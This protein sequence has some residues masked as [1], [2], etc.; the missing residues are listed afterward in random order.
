Q[1]STDQLGSILGAVQQLAGSQGTSPDNMQ[2]LMSIVGQYAR[3]S[4]KQT[5]QSAGRGEAESI[6][7]R[8]AGTGPS[9]DAMQA[10]FSPQQ[11]EK[12]ADT[13]SQR[14]GLNRDVIL[15]LLPIVVPLVLK[16]LQTGSSKSGVSRQSQPNSV[17]NIFLDSDNDGDVDM[18]D[19]ISVAS[20]F[21]KNR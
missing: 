8:F 21:L 4:L 11:R 5:S 9:V 19:A 13:A 6:V 10:L 15:S 7:D 3:S 20:R 1:A 16:F 12:I 14:T 2:M 17:L 18:G